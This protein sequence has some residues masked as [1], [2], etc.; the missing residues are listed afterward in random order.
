MTAVHIMGM[1]KFHVV[2][3]HRSAEYYLDSP[4]A[5]AIVNHIRKLSNQL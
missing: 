5:I 2:W 4:I 3:Y 1:L